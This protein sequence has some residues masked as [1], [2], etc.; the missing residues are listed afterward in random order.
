MRWWS[1]YYNRPMKDPLLLS[2]TEEEL[3]YE[4][5]SMQ[6]H[7]L[8]AEESL[9][10]EADKIE[11]EKDRKAQEWAE[12]MEKEDAEAEAKA[13]AQAQLSQNDLEWIQKYIEQEKQASGEDFGEDLNVDFDL[14]G[15]R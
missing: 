15:Q 1:R 5:N 2:Y 10:E 9:E 4:F 13:E 11:E 6:Q 8:A 7:V 12:Q 14:S 3:L